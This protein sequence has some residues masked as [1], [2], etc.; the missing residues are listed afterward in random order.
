MQKFYG[1]LSTGE[2][3]SLYTIT[4]GGLTAEVTDCGGIIVKLFVPD[5]NGHLADV[6]LGFDDP[7]EYTSRRGHF[8]GIVGRCTNRIAGASF[9]LNGKLY[10]LDVNDHDRNTLHSGFHPFKNRLW[11]VISHEENS[12]CLGLHCP[13]GDQGFPGNADIRVTYTLESPGT[14]RIDYDAVSD[15]DTVFNMTNHA[16]FNLAGHDH[17]E[18]GLQQILSMPARFYTP[19]DA[20]SIPT[21]ELRDVTGTPMDFRIPKA[22]GRDLEEDYESLNL[23]HGYDHNY[24][25]FTSP[26]AI[27]TDSDSGR[28]MA[29]ITDC[30]GVQLYSGNSLNGVVGKGGV[31]Y[32]RGAGICLETQFYPD[33]IHHPEWVQPVTKAGE[34]YRSQ[35]RYVFK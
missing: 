8:G 5:V 21:G 31:V 15:Q 20:D 10:S 27:L 34:H 4:G 13:N 23:Q 17:P 7:N 28:T 1:T 33:A 12:I 32:C 24:E 16:Y 30:P 19:A 18:K 25:A 9:T 3:A 11:R 29:V 6:V 2:T 22:I 35:T 14:L 26:C